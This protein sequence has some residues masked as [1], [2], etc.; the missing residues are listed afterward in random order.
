MLPCLLGLG[1]VGILYGATVIALVCGVG[2][3]MGGGEGY[4]VG[5]G[6]GLMKSQYGTWQHGC[7]GS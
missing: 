1:K 6:V 4:P 5:K 2:V 3:T 7:L